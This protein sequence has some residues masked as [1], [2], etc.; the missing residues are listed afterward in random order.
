MNQSNM[1]RRHLLALAG[2][3]LAR[4]GTALAIGL[5]PALGKAEDPVASEPGRQKTPSQ[6]PPPCRATLVQVRTH[7]KVEENLRNARRAFDQAARDRARWLLFPEMFLSGY[8]GKF[9]QESV[10][11]GMAEVA[12]L[13]REHRVASLVGTGWKEEGKTFNQVRILDAAGKLAG[14]YAK[15]CLCYGEDQWTSPGTTPLVFEVHG[16]K[17]G[18]LICNDLWVTPGFSDGPNPHWSLKQARAGAQV[19]FHHISSGSDQRYRA[20]HE[21]NHFARA[22]EARCEI[23]AVNAFTPPEVNA[24][25]GVVGTDFRHHDALQRNCEVIQTVEFHPAARA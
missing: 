21:S 14:V 13:C 25:S 15:K 17:F 1:N 7:P 19:I 5:L 16:V 2:N 22:A 20:Y 12:G 24:T 6:V 4:G 11:T 18:V 10:A 23:V 3:A 9:D 8:H